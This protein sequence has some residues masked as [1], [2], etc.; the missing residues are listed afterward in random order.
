LSSE[1]PLPFIPEADF[2]W[3][4]TIVEAE[5]NRWKVLAKI[6]S[7]NLTGKN[8]DPG[9]EWMF[10]FSRYDYTRGVKK[11]VLSSTSLHSRPH[12]HDRHD[13]GTVIFSE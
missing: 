3:S 11:P 4:E 2:F 9:E 5:H 1:E 13:W 8:I 12:F 7:T 10:S 6:I